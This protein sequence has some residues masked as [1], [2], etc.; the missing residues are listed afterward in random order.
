[1]TPVSVEVVGPSIALVN[2][3]FSTAD[4]GTSTLVD[5]LDA[6]YVSAAAVVT[7][8]GPTR[9]ITVAPMLA[10]TTSFRIDS[11]TNTRLSKGRRPPEPDRARG[12][13]I[14]PPASFGWGS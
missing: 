10:M 12:K 8:M 11:L 14:R 1:M 3:A 5:G 7:A 9:A 6:E 13:L 4:T 2:P